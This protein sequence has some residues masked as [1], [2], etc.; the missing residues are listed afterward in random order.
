MPSS[1]RGPTEPRHYLFIGLV[2]YIYSFCFAHQGYVPTPILFRTCYSHSAWIILILFRSSMSRTYSHCVTSLLSFWFVYAH[3]VQSISVPAHSHCVS[4]A[5]MIVRG[6]SCLTLPCQSDPL[7]RILQ[8]R[9]IPFEVLS[10]WA[11]RECFQ[12]D[13]FVLL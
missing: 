3:S 7:G 5:L 6:L 11:H 9:P 10:T 12:A 4:L 2:M 1:E 13:P 8:G